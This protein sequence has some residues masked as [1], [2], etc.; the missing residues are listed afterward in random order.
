MRGSSP[1]SMSGQQVSKWGRP[2]RILR[3]Y[4]SDPRAGLIDWIGT[5]GGTGSFYNPQGTGQQYPEGTSG[6]L[7]W[8]Q[9]SA[10]LNAIYP[11]RLLTDES[12]ATFCITQDAQNS[13]MWLA[14]SVFEFRPTHVA[15]QQRSDAATQLYGNITIA[16]SSDNSSWTDVGNI[17]SPTQTTS[18]WNVGVVTTNHWWRFIRVLM[19]GQ[20]NTSDNYFCVGEFEIFGEMRLREDLWTP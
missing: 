16:V 12:A 3:H 10:V 13:W 11:T 9:A 18:A 15:L 8:S 5:Q 14:M 19:T 4:G 7:V 20:S 2:P 17:T 6:S 1:R